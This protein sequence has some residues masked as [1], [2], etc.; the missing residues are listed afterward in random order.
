MRIDGQFVTIGS[1]SFECAEVLFHPSLM[2]N[3]TND[4]GLHQ[5]VND[6]IM[7]CDIDIHEL[8]YGNLILSGGNTKWNEQSSC[9]NS[10]VLLRRL[11][12][13]IL[14]LPRL[15]SLQFKIDGKMTN[16]QHASWI[17]A[18]MV[19]SMSSFKDSFITQQVRLTCCIVWEMKCNLSV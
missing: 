15:T 7:A 11:C 3:N 14:T 4:R 12:H 10:S 18:A 6:G 2:T 5:L 9:S 16:E 13:E 19:G 17:G 8:L 1:E